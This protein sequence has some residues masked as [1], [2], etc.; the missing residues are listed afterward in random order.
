M[1]RR[2]AFFLCIVWRPVTDDDGDTWLQAWRK[3][4]LDARTAWQ[5]ART[6]IP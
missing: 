6:L 1:I 2:I 3:Y 5:I 4:R